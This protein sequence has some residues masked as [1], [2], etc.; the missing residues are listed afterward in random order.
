M[1]TVY[2]RTQCAACRV[3]KD[4]L[5]HY[6]KE[7]ELIN[8]DNEPKIA[9]KWYDKGVRQVPIVQLGDDYFSGVNTPKLMEFINA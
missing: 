7:F 4:M 6:E 5:N 3:I 1:I 8:L 2:T 9:Q